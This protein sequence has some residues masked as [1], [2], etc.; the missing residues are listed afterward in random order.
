MIFL[1]NLENEFP[2]VFYQR[3]LT[4]KLN[5]QGIASAHVPFNVGF[6]KSDSRGF[7]NT[8]P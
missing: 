6:G 1:I 4:M 3:A 2:E 7:G 8:E 5:L